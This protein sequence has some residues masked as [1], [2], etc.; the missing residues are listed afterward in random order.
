MVTGCLPLGQ[1]AVSATCRSPK[2]NAG[3]GRG[4]SI[5]RRNEAIE[6]GVDVR[7]FFHWTGV[8]NYEWLHGFDVSF[9]I[10]DRDRNVRP[11][12]RVLEREAEDGGPARS[13]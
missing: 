1:A 9:G 2:R 10:I 7:G 4:G 8:D 6:R 12:A 3:S 11:S 5:C 13:T